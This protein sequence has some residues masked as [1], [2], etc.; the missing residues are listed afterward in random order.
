MTTQHE[1]ENG[2]GSL[3]LADRG[4]RSKELGAVFLALAGVRFRG[5]RFALRELGDVEDLLAQRDDS[6][7]LI[8]ESG[9]VP[10]EDIGFVRRFLERQ[11]GWNLVVLG[12]DAQDSRARG[13]LALPRTQWLPWPPDLE[14]LAA[15]LGNGSAGSPRGA[16]RAPAAARAPLAGAGEE[17]HLDDLLEELLAAMSLSGAKAPRFLYRS[18]ETLLLHGEAAP[19]QEGLSGLFELARVCAGEGQ[20]V[21]VAAEGVDERVRIR[22]D[23]PLGPLTDADL[24]G[25]LQG[26]FEGS[27]ELARAVETARRGAGLL[28]QRGASVELLAHRAG[29]LRLE[30]LLARGA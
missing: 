27:P 21:N 28:E 17:V 3:L 4:E 29:R 24:P 8:L 14:Q 25:L 9:R 22:V 10:A 5:A 15:L 2:A 6:G 16:E 19:L 12:D 7:T 11:P 1:N 20:V 18:E 23:F 13:L 26:S 30:V